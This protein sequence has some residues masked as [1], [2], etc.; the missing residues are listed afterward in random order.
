MVSI[1]DLSW[2]A[3]LLEG[4]GCFHSKKKY[5]YPLVTCAMT[6]EDVI[7]RLQNLLGGSIYTKTLD[8]RGTYKTA[9]RW[10]IQ[11]GK[12]A[13]IMMTLYPFLFSRRQTKIR[14]ILTAWRERKKYRTR[15]CR[16]GHQF[17]AETTT[18]GS[19][20]RS[21]QQYYYR[22]CRI[23]AKERGDLRIANKVGDPEIQRMILE[24]GPGSLSRERGKKA[25]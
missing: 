20:I 8:P 23:C 12:A 4:E 22:L 7:L 11:G 21:G 5:G 25:K 9:Y 13:G 24:D 19:M 16:R 14:E 17:T 6:D 3:G 15:N 10:E 2:I 1:M 18:Y